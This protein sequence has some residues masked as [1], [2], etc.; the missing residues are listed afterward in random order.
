MYV[1]FIDVDFIDE[2]DC[3]FLRR[4]SKFLGNRK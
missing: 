4:R 3:S 1:F 2:S